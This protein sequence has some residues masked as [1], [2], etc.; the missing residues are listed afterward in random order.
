[1]CTDN[2]KPH[3]AADCKENPAEMDE[4]RIFIRHI[5]PMLETAS[6]S[7]VECVYWLLLKW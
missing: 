5:L 3:A 1:M 4:K 7:K 6:L 2:I